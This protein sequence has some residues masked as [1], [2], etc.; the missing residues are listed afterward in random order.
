MKAWK[1]AGSYSSARGSVQAWLF[2]MAR[3]VAIDRIRQKRADPQATPFDP[4][5]LDPACGDVTP[6]QK[7]AAWE[8]RQ[9]IRQVL[10]GLPA[11]Q[12]KALMLAFFEGFSHFELAE[13]LGAP[14]G[15]IKTRIRKRLL[16]LRKLLVEPE[17]L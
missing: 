4:F 1:N 5:A 9:H 7:A 16:S 3:S 15:T 11:E 12:R 2:M 6:E 8:R 17:A 13:R 10:S 14:L